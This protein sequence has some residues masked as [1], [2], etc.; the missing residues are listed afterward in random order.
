MIYLA[1]MHNSFA[2]LWFGWL[3]GFVAIE[4]WALIKTKKG[5]VNEGGTLTELIR[6]LAKENKWVMVVFGMLWAV[7]TY[8]FFFDA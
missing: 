8:H 4:L 6:R 1:H 7:L 2:I 3:L 5:E